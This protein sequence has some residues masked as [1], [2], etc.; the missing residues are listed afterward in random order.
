M[1]NKEILEKAVQKAIDG[2]WIPFNND[3]QA[4]QPIESL[5][6]FLLE[7]EEIETKTGYREYSTFIF[8]H[9]FAKALWGDTPLNFDNNNTLVAYEDRMYNE[10]IWQYH[11][12][13]MV[14]SPNPIEYLGANI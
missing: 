7:N 2:G 10:P 14:I 1:T 4:R 13:Q 9:E 3:F 5:M 6:E 8:N 11:L 12:Q